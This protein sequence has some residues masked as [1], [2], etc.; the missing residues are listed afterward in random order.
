LFA[1]RPGQGTWHFSYRVPIE[2]HEGKK[3]AQI[4]L[5][6]ASSG[7]VRLDSTRND[8][9][10]LTG[11]LWAKSSR[12]NLVIHEIGVAGEELLVVEWRDQNGGTP[13][14]TE[15]TREFYGIGVKRAQHLTVIH[16]DGSCIH[17]AEFDVP[18]LQA[19]EFRMKL[20]PDVR[21]ISASVNGTELASPAVE[22]QMCQIRLPNRE[23]GQTV[24]RLSF[25]LAYPAERLGFVGVAE[26]ALPE[27]F[28]TVGTLEWVLTLPAGFE[29]QIISSGLEAQKSPSDLSRFGDYGNILKSQPH[30]YLAKN[31]T[32]PGRVNLRLKYRQLVSG[33]YAEAK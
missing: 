30:T 5:L 10:I 21:L 29:A 1:E 20:P 4:P 16:S 28:Q 13:A 3:R 26:R 15:G 22:D 32:P 19:Q 7:S 31:L 23:A 27:L 11:S 25:R 6:L 2:N 9:E 12:E 8:L 24:H 17:F 14:Q 18:V 33:I